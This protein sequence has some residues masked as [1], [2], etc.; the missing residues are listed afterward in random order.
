MFLYVEAVATSEQPIFTPFGEGSQ[1]SHVLISI[2]MKLIPS[3]H[4]Y[5]FESYNVV[6]MLPCCKFILLGFD[7]GT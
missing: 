6:V 7:I 4:G 3:Y 2:L 1:N 5:K